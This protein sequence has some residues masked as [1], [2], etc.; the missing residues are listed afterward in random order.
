MPDKITLLI[1]GNNTLHRTHW[2]ANN[3]GRPLVNS[4]G[5]NVGNTF[6]FLKT[7]KSYVDLFNADCV[8]IAWDKKLTPK[9]ANFRNTL[10]EGSYKGAR[11]QDR[12]KEVYA[13]VDEIVKLTD[14][15]G[16]KNIFP[17]H[18]EADDV[19]AYLSKNL[20]GK[21]IIISVDRDFIQLVN[22][23][24]SFYSPVKKIV[25]DINNFQKEHD[26]TPVEYL[27]YKA[28]IGDSSDNISGIQGYGNVKG[29]KLAKEIVRY[30]NNE[31]L[32][33]KTI[34]IIEE[35]SEIISH[36]IKLMDLS[37]GLGLYPEEGE[38]YKAQVDRCSSYG[39]NFEKFKEYCVELEFN[40][41]LNKF[42]EWKKTFDKS[43]KND[44]LVEF[45]KRFE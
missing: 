36:N 33:E 41:I 8:F 10:T 28:I 44:L 13:S 21:K 27:F 45:F 26:M 25:L 11:D 2:V 31:V 19:I 37:Y 29:V 3:I 12:N 35:A 4:K 22:E 24:V 1:D 14:L 5:V 40:S 20:D 15:I 18:L 23:K 38:L 6:T 32:P 34:K 42:E 17:G 16:I 43:A 39:P 30:K 9:I 7:I